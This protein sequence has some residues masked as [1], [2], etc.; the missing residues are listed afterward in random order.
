MKLTKG[1]VTLEIADDDKNKELKLDGF[2]REGFVVVGEKP[3][4][5][6]KEN[7]EGE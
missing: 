2:K 1:T 7:K 3:K 6:E 5:A 4:K